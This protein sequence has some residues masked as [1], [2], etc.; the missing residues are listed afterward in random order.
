MD[1]LSE[2]YP[3][4]NAKGAF[5]KNGEFIPLS[6]LNGIKEGGLQNYRILQY[7][8]IFGGNAHEEFYE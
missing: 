2:E 1:S 8:N 6:E 5:L 7:E 3:A 4:I